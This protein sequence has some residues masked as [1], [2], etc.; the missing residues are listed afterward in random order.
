M[1]HNF[2]QDARRERHYLYAC[3]VAMVLI[4]AMLVW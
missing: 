3:V 2:E 1:T 4:V